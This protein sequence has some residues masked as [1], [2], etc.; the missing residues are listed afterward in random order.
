MVELAALGPG[1]PYQRAFAGDSFNTA[2]Y[3]ARAGL[4]VDYLTRLGDDALSGDIL[5]M[6]E[7]EGIGA[8]LV[9]RVPGRQPGLYLID[10]D[11]DGERRFSY[12]RDRAP[13]REMFDQPLAVEEIDALYFTGITLAVTRS[14]LPNL[15]ELLAGARNAGCRVLFDP[16]YRAGLWDSRSQA[17]EHFNAVLPLCDTVL[18]TLDDDTALWGVDSVRACQEL[19]AG[20]GVRELVI[21]GAALNV[22]VFTGGATHS[23]QAE[24][25][26]ALDTTGAGDAF[27]A[28]YLSQRLRG[29]D[30]ADSIARGQALAAQVV[31]YRGAILPR[32]E[33]TN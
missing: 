7:A 17:R 1:G 28:G 14:G 11:D 15:I 8:G 22:H 19:Y 4:Q 21:R 5:R 9:R 3:L 18:S 20:R 25:V 2:V 12:W 13:V 32:P 6:L 10:N 31:Q 16:N 29:G 24:A 23:R 27:N 30:P 26:P 33:D